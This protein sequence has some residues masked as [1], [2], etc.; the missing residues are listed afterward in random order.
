M[1][2]YYCVSVAGQFLSSEGTG[3]FVTQSK[4]NHSCCPNAEARF[5]Y[6]NYI[7]AV[8]ATKDIQPGE[9]ICISYLDECFLE[10]SRHTRQKFL[11]EN[12]LFVCKCIKCESQVDDPDVTSAEEE[13]DGDSDS[14]M[15]DEN[16][17]DPTD[18]ID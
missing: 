11:A 4:I 17:V 13:S 10:R 6:S 9:E 7:V 18:E 14:E 15:E 5:P 2:F 8:T 16:P 12:Y 1:P 3:L